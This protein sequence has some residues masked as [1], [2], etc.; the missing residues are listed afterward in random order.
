MS[1]LFPEGEFEFNVDEGISKPTEI[2]H[3]K[4]PSFLS[5]GMDRQQAFQTAQEILN[6]LSKGDNKININFTGKLNRIG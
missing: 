4:W 2:M 1:T 5:V 3:P 6:F